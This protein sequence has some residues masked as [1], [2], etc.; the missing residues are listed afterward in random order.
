MNEQ[1]NRKKPQFLRKLNLLDST[2]LVIGGVIGSGIFMTAGYI[3]EY[4]PSPGLILIV[5][6]VG[7]LITISGALSFAELGAMFPRAGGQY[8]YIR[9]AYGPWAGFFLDCSSSFYINP[10]RRQLLWH[11]DWNCSSEYIYFLKVRFCCCICYL[12]I[13]AW[14]KIWN[15]EL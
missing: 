13:N 7:G 1:E 8:I 6:L 10:F 12:R 15:Y 14:K 9:E 3:A 4:I 11:K 5:W 2:F